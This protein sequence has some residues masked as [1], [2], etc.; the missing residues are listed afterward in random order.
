MSILD[1]N[2]FFSFTGKKVSALEALCATYFRWWYL[3]SWFLLQV[4]CIQH[5]VLPQLRM[6]WL[7]LL[8]FM[9]TG[10][11]FDPQWIAL[12]R[13]T[14][15]DFLNR[16][17]EKINIQIL[18]KDCMEQLWI[19]LKNILEDLQEEIRITFKRKDWIGLA[20]VLYWFL[21]CE[22]YSQICFYIFFIVDLFEFAT[23]L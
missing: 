10:N 16:S 12:L 6:S 5:A 18:M 11:W 9:L 1:A 14:S 21:L 19:I 8:S 13:D 17:L 23:K 4:L 15:L 22:C 2:A 3:L 20:L 7:K